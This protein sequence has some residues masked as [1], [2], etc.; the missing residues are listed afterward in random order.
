M[1]P[2]ETLSYQ[3]TYQNHFVMH[4]IEE[5][6]NFYKELTT[7]EP[8]AR[9]FKVVVNNYKQKKV[10]RLEKIVDDDDTTMTA[11]P[12]GLPPQPASYLRYPKYD[13]L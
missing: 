12:I 4:V 1:T 9:L 6:E 2:I 13:W 5:K 7:I 3:L 10:G 11:E 8:S